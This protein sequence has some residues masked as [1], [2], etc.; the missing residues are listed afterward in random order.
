VHGVKSVD[1]EKFHEIFE[2]VYKGNELLNTPWFHVLGNH[3][4]YGNAQ[5][6]IDYTA[7]SNR[8]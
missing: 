8:W 3:D 7:K 2:E 6:Q 4:H 1:D 5:A